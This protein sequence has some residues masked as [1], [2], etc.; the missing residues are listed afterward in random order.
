MRRLLVPLI[1]LALV[2]PLS[3]EVRFS[4]LDLSPTHELLFAATAHVPG[5]GEYRALFHADLSAVP[6]RSP[7]GGVAGGDVLSD[8]AIHAMTHYPEA[9][10]YLPA[11]QAI[12]IQ[13][14]FGVFRGDVHTGAFAPVSGFDG[15]TTGSE[16]AVGRIL[17]VTASPD[18][19][20]LLVV[21]PTSVAYG[22]LVLIA[23]DAGSRT[24][25]RAPERAT[26]ATRVELSTEE[27]PARWSPDSRYFVYGRGG[28]VYYFSIDQHERGRS[29]GESFRELGPGSISSVRWSPTGSLYYVSG[30]LVY[31]IL[32]PEFFTRSLYAGLLPAGTIIGK[33]PFP[34]DPNFDT[35][36][37]GPDGTAILLNKGG[38]NLFLLYLSPDDYVDDG[39]IV[40]LPS[41]LLPRNTRV[42]DVAWSDAGQITV[43]TGSLVQGSESSALFRLNV[44]AGQTDPT[45]V[46][47]EDQGVRQLRLA[48]D[49]RLIALL[50]DDGIRFRDHASWA[51]ERT[52]AVEDPLHA[53]WIDSRRLLVGSSATIDTV[54]VDTGQ[55]RFVALSQA[56]DHSIGDDGRI[57]A[58]A[59]GRTWVHDG[60]WRPSDAAF[61]APRRVTSSRFRVF[62]ETLTSGSYRSMVMVRRVT[63]AGTSRLF[64]PPQR[65]YE[66]F[67]AEDEP[68]DFAHFTHGSRI[69]RREIAL[70]FDAIDSVEGL[71]EILTTLAGYDVRATFFVNGEFVRRH[72]AALTEI[73][74]A[75][76]EVGSLFFA[77]L[78]MSDRRFRITPH[79]I[80]EGLA[81]N[82][83][84]FF[85]A[86]GQELS[87]IWHA[88][89]YFVSDEIIA[90]GEQANYLYVGR[91]VDS[92]DWV[93]RR[94]DEGLSRLYMPAADLVERI[95]ELKR[96]GSI[97]SMQV[98]VPDE[99]RSGRDD[100]LF[101]RLDVL[102]NA[103]IDRGYD[104]VPVSTL[105]ERA[106]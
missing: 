6:D 59:S 68:V 82:E 32:G 96:P 65:S 73:L 72:P 69:R 77:H 97:V 23:T 81:R 50:T 98:G 46:R 71:T 70:V 91:D 80:R 105:I 79:F 53:V 16:V 88:P 74:A 36:H 26:I 13:N 5:S 15:F 7:I 54:E 41:L 48:P 17:P 86:T 94:T 76:H 27:E 1:A 49:E 10:V 90:A 104:V 100:Y 28:S 58:R 42:R 45:F 43:L 18:G 92:L 89:Y 30:S 37:M 14:R 106:R 103:L 101:Q 3:A 60:V 66:P 78:D 84:E 95:I 99:A 21:E 40:G 52:V 34:F 61:D 51:T 11:L 12:Q 62:L 24:A 83:D 39:R 75:G 67:P 57:F 31:E 55:L 47:T 2:S 64:S 87:L 63:G 56:D 19:R 4:D 20:Y 85:R 25:G 35:F 102:M 38:R 29:L 93:A 22:D 9:L 8:V 33:L 44:H